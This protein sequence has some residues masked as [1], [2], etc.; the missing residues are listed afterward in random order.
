MVLTIVGPK[1]LAFVV[2]AQEMLQKFVVVKLVIQVMNVEEQNLV[3]HHVE[4]I[5][6][7]MKVLVFVV[8]AQVT[9]PKFVVVKT[10]GKEM[11]VEIKNQTLNQTL[12]PPT[13]SQTCALNTIKMIL[14]TSQKDMV[15]VK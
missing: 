8:V 12:P 2:V 10:V 7:G 15:N 13:P 5:F 11:N 1:V 9:P 4:I 14:V 3:L 6:V